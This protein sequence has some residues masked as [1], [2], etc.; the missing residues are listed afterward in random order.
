[1]VLPLDGVIS[2]NLIRL[3]DQISLV[4]DQNVCK[5][6]LGSTSGFKL[7]PNPDYDLPRLCLRSPSFYARR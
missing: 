4:L 2:D 3:D 5:L 6:E 1:M 7:L